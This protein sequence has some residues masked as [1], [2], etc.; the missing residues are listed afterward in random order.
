M[1]TRSLGVLQVSCRACSGWTIPIPVLNLRPSTGSPPV[2][3]LRAL[4]ALNATLNQYYR[5]S[6]QDDR[7][8][9]GVFTCMDKDKNIILT[10]TEEYRL[11]KS[12]TYTKGSLQTFELD[13]LRILILLSDL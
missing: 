5:I 11:E 2:L 3:T 8:F 4:T 7:V 13:S 12:A 1:T 6:I 10:N 9:I